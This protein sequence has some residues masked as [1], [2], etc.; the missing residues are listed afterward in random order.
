MR[1]TKV[2][3]ATPTVS[4]SKKVGVTEV[5]FV[6]RVECGF[7]VGQIVGVTVVGSFVGRNECG[8][9]L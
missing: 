7:L 3:S 2:T 5:T 6:G 8:L 9:L 1:P 4:P